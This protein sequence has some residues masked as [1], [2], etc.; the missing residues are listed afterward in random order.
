MWSGRRKIGL[1]I[2]VFI[3]LTETL[4]CPKPYPVPDHT[5][6][7][8][9][10]CPR[11]YPVPDRTL[12]Q[13]VPCPRPYPVQDRTL[14]QIFL[15]FKLSFILAQL[16]DIFATISTLNIA[17]QVFDQTEIVAEEKE[18]E[19]NHVFPVIRQK[20]KM[21]NFVAHKLWEADL[22]RLLTTRM[23]YSQSSHFTVQY[24]SLF[25]T[26]HIIF[27]SIRYLSVY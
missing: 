13:T 17:L 14:S 9:V 18:W 19:Q 24:I 20:M 16:W 12:S 15:N 1:F 3:C 6:S 5:L 25:V 27:C 23:V 4:P 2:Y 21:L 10:P 8:T 7:Q 11:L 26:K 22:W